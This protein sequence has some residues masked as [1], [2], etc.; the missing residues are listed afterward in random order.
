[1]NANGYN[2]CIVID[3]SFGWDDTMCAFDCVFV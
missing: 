1:M 2:K 3:I